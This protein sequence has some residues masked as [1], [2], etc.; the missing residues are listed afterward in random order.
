M[1][2]VVDRQAH[3]EAAFGPPTPGGGALRSVTLRY[4]A[5]M[6]ADV[7]ARVLR[8]ERLTAGYNV[9]ALEAPA[10]AAGVEPGQFVMI[11]TAPGTDPLL[12][13]PFSV[14]EVLREGTEVI[15]FSIL[16]KRAGVGT[17]R[18]AEA[19]V[20]ERFWC[21]GP[22]GHPF[23]LAAARSEAWMVAGGVGLA[24]FATLAERLREQGTVPRLFYGA[25]TADE[26]FRVELFESL[27]VLVEIAT[28]DGSRGTPGR[29]TA[30]LAAAIDG[31][32]EGDAVTL[33]ACG[34]SAM[35]QAVAT[36]AR[37]SGRDV[38]V[39]LEQ[40]MGCGTGGCYSCVVGVRRDGRTRYVRSCL[41][42]P[43][44]SSAEL[45][46]STVGAH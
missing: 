21:L 37:S 46:W 7:H 12:R 14:F 42:G 11:R 16:N 35:M 10:L 9:L 2:S 24:P 20:N 13:R 44:F 33:Y 31:L 25:R 29:V 19:S 3:G 18:L 15:G 22:L 4:T 41:D 5:H 30:P 34:P 45:D 43:V 40:V 27:G 38:E 23:S 8:N 32:A 39:S 1:T 28:E 17:S 36:M 26:L 6:F